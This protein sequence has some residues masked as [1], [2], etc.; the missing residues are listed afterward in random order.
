MPMHPLLARVLQEWKGESIYTQPEDWVWASAAKEGK[1]PMAAS[2]MGR[3][4]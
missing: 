2:T 3:K 1:T 4:G